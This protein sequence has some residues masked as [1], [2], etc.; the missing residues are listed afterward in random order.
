MAGWHHRLNGHEFEQPQGDS[1]G[2]GSLEQ[3]S[4]WGA[5]ESDTTERLNNHH[6]I[7]IYQPVDQNRT[8]RKKSSLYEILINDKNVFQFNGQRVTNKWCW[9][10]WQA[11]WQKTVFT[12]INKK[13]ITDGIDAYCNKYSIKKLKGKLGKTLQYIF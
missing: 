6:N 13:Q 9:H 1:K 11:V 10:N 12:L 8:P 2:Q 3:C 7:E 5:K 4:P